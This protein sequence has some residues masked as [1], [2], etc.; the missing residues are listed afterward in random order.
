MFSFIKKIVAT[1]VL[2]IGVLFI[3]QNQT[4][5]SQMTMH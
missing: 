3:Y 1:I 5:L 2:A 4:P